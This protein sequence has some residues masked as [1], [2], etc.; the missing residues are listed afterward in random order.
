V[1]LDFL[2]PAFEREHG[3]QVAVINNTT[4]RKPK[5][6]VILGRLVSEI[7]VRG[8][9]ELGVQ[10]LSEILA[11]PDARVVMQRKGFETP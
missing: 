5:Y 6:N 4:Q 7:V 8:E 3:V 1:F 2:P 9:A 10:M 11:M